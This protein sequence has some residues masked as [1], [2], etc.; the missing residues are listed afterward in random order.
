MRNRAT[1]ALVSGGLPPACLVKL[2]RAEDEVADGDLVAEGAAH[3]A[4]AEGQALARAR[5][6]VRKVDVCEG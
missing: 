2:A 1:L 3:L 5:E 6:D 4:N